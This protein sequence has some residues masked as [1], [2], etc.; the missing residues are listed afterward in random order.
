[1]KLLPI[2]FAVALL[3]TGVLPAS[4]APLTF[5]TPP[6]QGFP[7]PGLPTVSAQSWIVY[8]E[9]SD[10][11]LASWDADTPRPMASITK[12]MTVMLGVEQGDPADRVTVSD[13]AASTI[14]QEIGLVAGESVSLGAL[15]RAALIRS[16]NDSAAAIAEHISGSIEGFVGVMNAR[17]AEL[18]MENTRFANPHGLDT[19]G[20]YSTPRDMLRLA[21][22]AMSLPAFAEIARA[23]ALVFPDA[24]DG[25]QRSATNTNR[26][27]NG[28]EGLTGVKTGQTPRAGLTYVGSAE[29]FGHRLFVVVFGSAGTRGHLVDAVRLFDWGFA[30]VQMA[31]AVGEESAESLGDSLEVAN[32]PESVVPVESEEVDQN[33][34]PTVTIVRRSIVEPTW[35][36]TLTY[37]ISL[38]AKAFR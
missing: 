13:E 27:L 23:K 9:T 7:L 26:I 22:K 36:D 38:T 25:S 32:E 28:Y 1:M 11:I 34:V 10:E 2:A 20:H 18:G 6:G 31:V 33:P 30:R 35:L 24:P 14:G 21:V 12:I 16:G 37:W 5:E 15:E 4:A 19:E 17:A 29:R 3:L 8:D